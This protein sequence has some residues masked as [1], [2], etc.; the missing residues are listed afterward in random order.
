M[1]VPA[2]RRRGRGAPGVYNVVDDDPAAVSEWLPHL[3]G[4]LGAKAPRRVPVWLARLAIGEP[5]IVLMT[6]MRGASNAKA[7]AELG[8]RP[9]Y[10]SWREGFADSLAGPAAPAFGVAA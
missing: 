2:R 1:V 8:W 9:Q 7:K 6:E 5:G 3:A 4:L 10:A